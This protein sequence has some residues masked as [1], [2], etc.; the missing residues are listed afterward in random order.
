MRK[1]NVTVFLI[2]L[3][4]LFCGSVIGSIYFPLKTSVSSVVI[5]HFIDFFSV[6]F[7]VWLNIKKD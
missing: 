1:F 4:G 2:Q 6:C 5:G 3:F 7:L